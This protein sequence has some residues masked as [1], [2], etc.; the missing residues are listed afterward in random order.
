M[1]WRNNLLATGASL[2]LLLGV[3]RIPL[4]GQEKH[5]KMMHVGRKGEV[6]ITSPIK[7]GQTVLKPGTYMFQHV[8]EGADHVVLFKKDGMEVARVT[9]RLESLGQKAKTTALYTH[10]GDGGEKILDAVAV[11]GEDFK[12]VIPS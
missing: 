9:C 2:V 11:R 12:H 7:V 5:Q 6:T 8:V 1:K 3:F 4:F 10:I